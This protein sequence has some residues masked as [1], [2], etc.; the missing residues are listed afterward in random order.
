MR[1][2]LRFPLVVWVWVQTAANKVPGLLEIVARHDPTGTHL[3][4]FSRVFVGAFVHV[5]HTFNM[6]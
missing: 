1:V 4:I 6:A 5:P 3:R 2:A